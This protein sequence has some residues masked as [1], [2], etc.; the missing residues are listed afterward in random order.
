MH[1]RE[2]NTCLPMHIRKSQIVRVLVM[3]H[4]SQLASSRNGTGSLSQVSSFTCGSA[5]NL[6]RSGYSHSCD[7]DHS[8]Y[9]NN[10]VA[11]PDNPFFMRILLITSMGRHGH[12]SSGTSR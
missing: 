6:R 10:A 12:S 2:S 1:G 11:R 9:P 8:F 5:V 3:I 4:S 7:A